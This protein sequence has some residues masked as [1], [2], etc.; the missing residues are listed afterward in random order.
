MIPGCSAW[1]VTPMSSDYK[2]RAQARVSLAPY[3]RGVGFGDGEAVAKPF[4]TLS[5]PPLWEQQF[6]PYYTFAVFD[7]PG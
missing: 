4:K 6:Y 3:S 1:V 5:S 7:Q 2:L